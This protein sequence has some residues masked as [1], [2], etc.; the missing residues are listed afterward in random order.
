MWSD[1]DSFSLLLFIKA[2]PAHWSLEITLWQVLENV[3]VYELEVSYYAL[4][5]W[6]FS[7]IMCAAICYGFLREK[8]VEL[9]HVVFGE[10]TGVDGWFYAAF[11]YVAPLDAVEEGVGAYIVTTCWPTAK[12]RLRILLHQLRD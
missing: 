12:P 8:A 6:A 2:I 3:W 11:F 4:V 1:T 10:N 7:L 9:G 5:V